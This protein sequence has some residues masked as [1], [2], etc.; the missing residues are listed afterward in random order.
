MCSVGWGPYFLV[1]HW[2]MRGFLPLFDDF[3]ER[4]RLGPRSR[5]TRLHDLEYALR[6]VC[7][8]YACIFLLA[9]RAVSSSSSSS[10]S[11]PNGKT[12]VA[13]RLGLRAEMAAFTKAL[14]DHGAP[15][16][17]GLAVL[18]HLVHAGK[19]VAFVNRQ[20][21]QAR[22]VAGSAPVLVKRTRRQSHTWL[23]RR[24]RLPLELRY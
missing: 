4:E 23:T 7:H 3:V 20:R 9:C 10:I 18:C 16:S 14:A 22:E 13:K 17:P 6:V 19:G 8:V 15:A 12:C 2:H 1:A 21:R 11:S 24:L 5:T